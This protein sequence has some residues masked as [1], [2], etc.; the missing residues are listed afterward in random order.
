MSSQ[1]CISLSSRDCSFL[2]S[3]DCISLSSQGCIFLSSQDCSC[4]S[5]FFSRAYGFSSKPA[6]QSVRR[7]INQQSLHSLGL[8]RLCDS[9][10]LVRK[11]A[12][13]LATAGMVLSRCVLMSCGGQRTLACRPSLTQLPDSTAKHA[14]SRL[15]TIDIHML[16]SLVAHMAYA[17]AISLVSTS[18]AF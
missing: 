10:R 6:K 7:V 16:V 18:C 4:C 12:L 17:R 13:F 11:T 5:S 14:T 9:E 3:Q 8:Q 2:S 15:L 1:G